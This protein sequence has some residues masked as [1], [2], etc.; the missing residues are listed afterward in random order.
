MDRPVSGFALGGYEGLVRIFC[1]LIKE[2]GNLTARREAVRRLDGRVISLGFPSDWFVAWGSGKDRWDEYTA[3][4]HEL[5]CCNGRE[6][7]V[8]IGLCGR[9]GSP[10]DPNSL[11]SRG[12]LLALFGDF[13][14]LY[15]YEV[16]DATLHLVAR[17]LEELCR[18]GVARRTFTYVEETIV[19]T[20]DEIMEGNYLSYAASEEIPDG[21]R[22]DELL[23][24]YHKMEG[25]RQV[26]SIGYTRMLGDGFIELATP[27]CGRSALLLAREPSELSKL[28]PFR[29][30]HETL[31]DYCWKTVT[32]KLKCAWSIVG[33]L[34]YRADGTPN[35]EFRVDHVLVVDVYGV[36]YA[37]LVYTRLIEVR[38]VSDSVADLFRMGMIR[39]VF[40]GS[41]FRSWTDRKEKLESSSRC[42]HLPERRIALL[43]EH[44]YDCRMFPDADQHREWLLT[45]TNRVHSHLPWDLEDP[46]VAPRLLDT[47]AQRTNPMIK[48][49]KRLRT[50]IYRARRGDDGRLEGLFKRG[51]RKIHI[52]RLTPVSPMYTQK[53]TL[54][55]ASARDVRTRR[56]DDGPGTQRLLDFYNMRPGPEDDEH[57]E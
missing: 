50:A 3:K 39:R 21:R 18:H 15:V 23:I 41:E 6:I 31:F 38:R 2:H 4:A 5:L 40:S 28:W 22:D 26:P 51:G 34:G 14:R 25:D 47:Q 11:R 17:S 8:P 24:V 55:P 33:V 57:D 27:G 30:L 37:L 7:L 45:C 35:S 19:K 32:E 48:Y 54:V 46:N 56:S 13:G 44:R 36:V 29:C 16:H 20:E 10:N 9:T 1:S 43:S 52:Y 12:D 49:E 53:Q 42:P